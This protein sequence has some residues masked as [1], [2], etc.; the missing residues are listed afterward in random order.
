MDAGVVGVFVP[1]VMFLVIGLILVTFF[2]FRSRERQMLIEKGMDAQSIKEF[3]ESKNK[4]KDPYLLMKIGIICIAFG[5]GLG[6]GLYMQD[7]SYQEFWVP[8]SLF[9]FTGIGFVVANIAGRKLSTKKVD[10]E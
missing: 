8:F 4:S 1:I 5:I 10:K 7:F 6:F 2:Y 9:T 3:F